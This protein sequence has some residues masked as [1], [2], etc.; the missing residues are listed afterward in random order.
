MPRVAITFHDELAEYFVEPYTG[1]ELDEYQVVVDLKSSHY[2][3]IL[4][5][6][7]RVDKDQKF[8]QNFFI[9]AQMA[10]RALR[11]Q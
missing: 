2:R 8:L 6:R 11:E 5:N 7:E 3:N 4:R 9:Q 10:G 1:W